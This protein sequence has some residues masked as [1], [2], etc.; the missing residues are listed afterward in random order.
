M[1]TA[2]KNQ[3][4]F[5]LIEMILCITILGI[6]AVS[7]APSFA[8]ILVKSSELGGRGAAGAIQS[9][10]W[11]KYAE[12]LMGNV[13]PAIPYPLDTATAGICYDSTNCFNSIITGF[14]S[15]NWRRGSAITYYYKASGLE[16]QYTYDQNTGEFRCSSAPSG[17][18]C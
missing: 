8:T 7:V 18:N 12:N 11:T 3:Q 6:L 16:W 15:E 13:T 2:M 5:T 17:Y 1:Q 4:G 14:V 9:A 10:I